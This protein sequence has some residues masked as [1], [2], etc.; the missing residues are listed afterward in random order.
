M[1]GEA[2]KS[3]LDL[4]LLATV[5]DAPKHGYAIV[6]VLRARSRGRFDL[7][8]G[9]IYPALHR[10]EHLGLLESTWAA[11]SPRPRR[12]Y[13]LTPAGKV[14]LRSRRGDWDAFV[15][16]MAGVLND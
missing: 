16:A 2:L 14:A 5:R 7:P 15:S 11:G 1:A 13:T 12:L 4:L 3:H 8:E 10:L 6:E 9:T